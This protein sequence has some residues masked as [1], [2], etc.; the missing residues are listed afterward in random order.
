MDHGVV[1]AT[2]ETA[3]RYGLNVITLAS[4]YARLSI[5]EDEPFDQVAESMR[6]LFQLCRLNAL[7]GLVVSKQAALD[8]RSS[9]R[10]AL[11]FIAIRGSA[12]SMR[13]AFVAKAGDDVRSAVCSVAETA[14]LQCAVF[15]SEEKAVKWLTDKSAM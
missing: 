3:A 13:L 8:W 1:A 5:G 4:G 12:P 2:D 14:G 6:M 11:R 15:R 10:V 9:M 7:H